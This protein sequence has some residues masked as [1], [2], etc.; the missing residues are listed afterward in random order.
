VVTGGAD[1]TVRVW[2]IATGVEEV[3]LNGHTSTVLSVAVSNDEQ[4]VLSG[5]ADASLRIWNASNGIYETVVANSGYSGQA[6]SFL[7]TPERVLST[8]GSL[9]FLWNT[10]TR[11]PAIA[12]VGHTSSLNALSTTPD[13][14]YMLT[15]SN[16]RTARLWELDSGAELASVGSHSTFS[17]SHT[18]P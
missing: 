2:N 11:V 5:G 12:Y 10:S 9:V 16:D 13:A 4:Q 3:R 14:R 15:G 18:S 8:S 1:N 17:F 6:V 7:P